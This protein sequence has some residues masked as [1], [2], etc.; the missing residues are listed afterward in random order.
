MNQSR[1]VP[2]C[3]SSARRVGKA[4]NVQRRFFQI[5][6][7]VPG[8]RVAVASRSSHCGRDAALVISVAVG[9]FYLLYPRNVYAETA[10]APIGIKFEAPRKKPISKE[11]NKDLISSQHLQVKKSW[12]N[13]GVYA[14]SVKF[15]YINQTIFE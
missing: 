15:P 14:W 1:T 12:E 7:K 9:A 2:H 3:L 10:S 11:E 13:P 8:S 4:S 6:S 5:H